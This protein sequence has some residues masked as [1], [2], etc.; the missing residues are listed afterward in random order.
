[1]C[2]I[3]VYIEEPFVNGMDTHVLYVVRTDIARD[4]AVAG[5]R[6]SEA[7]NIKHSFKW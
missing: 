2:I 4:G 3:Y 5:A 6:I 1:M 7:H